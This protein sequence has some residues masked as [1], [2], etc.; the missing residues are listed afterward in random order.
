MR[1]Y[2]IDSIENRSFTVSMDRCRIQSGI[3]YVKDLVFEGP[4]LDVHFLL[5]RTK[6]SQ[7]FHRNFRMKLKTGTFTIRKRQA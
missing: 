2:L 6:H 3:I 4:N 1:E 5:T 7:H